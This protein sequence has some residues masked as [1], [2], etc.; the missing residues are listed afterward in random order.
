MGDNRLVVIFDRL[1]RYFKLIHEVLSRFGE[2]V[3]LWHVREFLSG[4]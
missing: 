1:V 4:M 3:S 2:S